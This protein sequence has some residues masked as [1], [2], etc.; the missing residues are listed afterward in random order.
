MSI[1]ESQTKNRFKII[2]IFVSG[3]ILSYIPALKN[4]YE[5][6]EILFEKAVKLSS[7]NYIF[8]PSFSILN[9]VNLF[10]LYLKS[11][12]FLTFTSGAF[13]ILTGIFF[14]FIFRGSKNKKTITILISA[15]FLILGFFLS[16]DFYLWSLVPLYVFLISLY[17]KVEFKI[18]PILLIPVFTAISTPFFYD[19]D[20]IFLDVRDKVLLSYSFGEKIND[21]YYENT[22]FAAEVIKKPGIKK[23]RTFDLSGFDSQEEK[24][25]KRLLK[26]KSLFLL[27]KYKNNDLQILKT[28]QNIILKNK[29]KEIL[30]V[31][32]WDF[33]NKNKIILNE[34]NE[35]TDKAD[36]FRQ[37]T[38]IGFLTGFPF[39]F[40]FI[41]FYPLSLTFNFIINKNSA[42]LTASFLLIA[43]FLFLIKPVV[44]N[45]KI[46]TENLKENLN[47]NEKFKRLD[48]LKFAFSNKININNDI[49]LKNIKSDFI[50]ERYWALLNFHPKTKKDLM[51]LIDGTKDTSIN[52]RCKAYEKFSDAAKTITLRKTA[53]D[54]LGNDFKTIKDWYVQC[55]AY[56][57]MKKMR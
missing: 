41:C 12:L 20:S 35:K 47:S 34:F 26:G 56:L 9:E 38:L 44:F 42:D 2:F 30:K 46:E 39:F 37:I 15:F 21:F 57:A 45:N 33:F 22:L 36:F 19:G 10:P 18:N 17:F 48:A 40:Y 53:K 49:L 4:I 32:Y 24:R 50:P 25:I 52:V 54:F 27:K 8:T 3:L 29:G 51:V 1:L 6:N 23:L 43:V 13:L 11:A 16:K 31:G 5:T 55:Y 14:Y 7:S 28:K